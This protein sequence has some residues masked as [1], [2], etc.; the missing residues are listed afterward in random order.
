[1]ATIYGKIKK[2][3]TLTILF[4]LIL[5]ITFLI[6]Y[7]GYFEKEKPIQPS[8][9]KE[10]SFRKEKVEIDF[11]ILENPILNE[12]LP[13]EKIESPKPENLGRENPFLPIQ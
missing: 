7:F 9:P 6:L 2:E 1:M 8:F 10:V 11:T 5:G 13:T 4:F 12:L 3:K